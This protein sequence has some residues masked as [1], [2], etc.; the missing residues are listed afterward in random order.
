MNRNCGG[1]DPQRQLDTGN[2]HVTSLHLFDTTFRIGVTRYVG[3][4]NASAPQYAYQMGCNLAAITLTDLRADHLFKPGPSPGRIPRPVAGGRICST[5]IG[6]LCCLTL[7][8]DRGCI[9]LPSHMHPDCDWTQTEK[10]DLGL[11][12]REEPFSGLIGRQVYSQWRSRSS[13]AESPR[14]AGSETTPGSSYGLSRPPRSG[15]RIGYTIAFVHLTGSPDG[16]RID[17][18]HFAKV[19]ENS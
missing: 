11:T 13:Q 7:A 17:G 5:G 12:G 2:R 8:I 15:G 14:Q 19:E 1:R 6:G 10:S 18:P 9:D 16:C 3:H 4:D